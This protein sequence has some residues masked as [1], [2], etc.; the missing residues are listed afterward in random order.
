MSSIATRRSQSG[1]RVALVH[2]WLVGMRGA[3]ACLEVFAESFPDADIYTLVHRKGGLS[4]ALESRNIRTTFLQKLPFAISHHRHFLPLMPAAI[5]SLDLSGYDLVLSSSYC[6][7]RGVVTSP[8]TH[9]VSYCHTP[10]RYVWEQQHEYF[11]E[12]RAS[13]PV[14]AAAVFATHWLRNWDESS[15]RRVDHYVANSHHVARRIRKRYGVEADVVHPPVS[16]DRFRIPEK[17]GSGDYY[18]MLTAFAPYKRVDLAIEAFQRMGKRLL[19]GG[20]GQE[21]AKLRKRVKPGGPVELVGPVPD[22]RLADFLGGAKAFIFPGEEDFGIA[23]VEAQACGV[24]VIAFGRGGALETV[25]GVNDPTDASTDAQTRAAPTGLFFEEQTVESLIDAVERFEREATAFDPAAIRAHALT[26]DRPRFKET[27]ERLVLES[28]E[29]G[30]VSPA[31]PP[32]LR[33]IG[34]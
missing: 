4:P 31:S 7:A 18:V 6:V 9:H 26:F 25:V 30:T 27:M 29:R 17:P 14:R 11:G 28:F 10:M 12:G 15:G 5:E 34:S 24:P 8:A 33:L 22:A 19:I 20:G 13:L 21:G 32:P 2:D 1:P 16:C 23:P 3:E